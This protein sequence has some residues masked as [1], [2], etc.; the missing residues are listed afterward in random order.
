MEFFR[1]RRGLNHRESFSMS[2]ICVVQVQ[3][4]CS[5]Q[6]L[7]RSASVRRIN[8]M[9]QAGQEE[10]KNCEPSEQLPTDGGPRNIVNVDPAPDRIMSVS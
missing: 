1:V 6:Q 2:V 4:A 3:S 8:R 10:K 9:F 5:R 7:A